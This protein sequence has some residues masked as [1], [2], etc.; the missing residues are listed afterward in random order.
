MTDFAAEATPRGRTDA[1]DNLPA[2]SVRKGAVHFLFRCSRSVAAESAVT[3]SVHFHQ[4][5]RSQ[6]VL[7][8]QRYSFAR[9]C[10][11]AQ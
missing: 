2:T 10:D 11:I 3:Y 4:T 1:R 9:A 7:Q 6:V 5:E 8:E